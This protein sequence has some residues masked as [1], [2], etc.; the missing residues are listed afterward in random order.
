[1][2]NHM[3]HLHRRIGRGLTFEL[4]SVGGALLLALLTAPAAAVQTAD[5]ESAIRLFIDCHADCDFDFIRREIGF[6]SFVR[7]RADS[8]VHLLITAE[9]TGGGGRRYTLNFIGNKEFDGVSDTLRYSAL[10]TDTESLRRDGLVR[11]I[12]MGLMKFIAASPAAAGIRISYEAPRATASQPAGPV[13]D[14]WNYWVFR[15]NASGNAGG[16]ALRSNYSLNGNFSANRTTEQ[17]KFNLNV[18][19][20]YRESRVTL[21]DGREF[22]N[23]SRDYNG[24]MLLV[25]SLGDHLSAGI[26]MN[27]NSSIFSNEEI[28]VRF[29]PAL[30]YSLFPY[31]Q[32]SRR[33]LTLTYTVGVR[34][35]DYHEETIYLK[36]IETLTNERLQLAYGAQQPWGGFDFS[37]EGSHY[38]H[39]AGLYRIVI[40]LGTNVR[41]FKG[42]SLNFG[43][44]YSRIRDQLSLAREEAS[45]EELLVQRQQLRTGYRYG[46]NMGVSYSFGSIFNN[47]VNPRM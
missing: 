3:G 29:A 18:R 30:E 33:A 40:D 7:D 34:R 22:L 28:S 47:V 4:S 9:G 43:G 10:Q 8:Q 37:L 26:Q 6:V 19:G 44:D 16:E 36:T 38:F 23:D 41:L 46:F 24:N 25:K 17:W 27:A 14:P 11:T 15:F 1:M 5:Q 31:E 45:D 35:V 20:N 42:F 32:S 12:K 21:S 2:H 13:R 39:D